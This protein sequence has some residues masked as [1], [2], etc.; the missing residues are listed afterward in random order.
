[1][2]KSFD[3]SSLDLSQS[4]RSTGQYTRPVTALHS[5]VVNLSRLQYL[6]ISGTNL[7]AACSDD[8]RPFKGWVLLSMKKEFKYK[9]LFILINSLKFLV[10][11]FEAKMI[12]TNKFLIL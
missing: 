7:I 8:D 5:L 4:E 6:D 3:F 12:I 9:L 1:M 2:V 10:V 11:L